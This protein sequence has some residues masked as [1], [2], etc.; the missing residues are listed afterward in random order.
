MFDWTAEITGTGDRSEF[1]LETVLE[2]TI[3]SCYWRYGIE[4]LVPTTVSLLCWL[5]IRT[6]FI[7][8]ILALTTTPS[9]T[10][11]HNAK[12]KKLINRWHRRTLPLEPSHRC[13]IIVLIHDSHL[14]IITHRF[15]F[16]PEIGVQWPLRDYAV[17]TS[18]SWTPICRFWFESMEQSTYTSASD[19]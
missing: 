19:L 12:T 11:I 16:R 9:S 8:E 5:L 17:T 14:V 7:N 6:K 13:I 10:T 4:A 3:Y 1:K 2:S 15:T 18:I